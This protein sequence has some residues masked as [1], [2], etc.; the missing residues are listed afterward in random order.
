MERSREMTQFLS[1]FADPGAEYS[2]AP[3][4][5]WNDDLSEEEISRQMADFRAHGVYGFVIHPRAGLPR[6]IQWMSRRM[7]DFIRFAVEEAARTGMWVVLYDEGMYPSGSSAGQVVDADPNY[8]PHGLFCLDATEY[9]NRKPKSD[10]SLV[11]MVDR[12]NGDKVAIVD[13]IISEGFSVIRGLHFVDDDPPRRA[14]KK[15]VAEDLPPAADILNPDAMACF[16]RLVYQRYY[17]ELAEH[18]GK[19]I[20]AIFT[21]EPSFMGKRSEPGAVPGN[22]DLVLYVSNYLG[23]DFAPHLPSLWFD[24]EPE[25]KRHRL[26]YHRALKARLEE[27]YYQPLSEWCNS[28]GIALTGH[29]ADPDDIGQLKYFQIPGQDIVLRSVEPG[30]DSALV[31]PQSTQAKCA[32][33]AM[34]HQGRNRNSNEYCGAYGHGFTFDEMKWLANWLL[35]RGCNLLYPHAF[36]Y[37]VRGPRI[38]ERPPDVGP[39]SS[40]WNQFLP[41]AKATSRLCWLNTG[42]W[43]VCSMA[44]LGLAD[45]LPWKAAKVCFE[46]QYDFNYLETCY[47]QKDIQIT[48]KGISIG[49]MCYSGLIVESDVSVPDSE[50]MAKIERS[51]R[52]IRWND[53]DGESR[54]LKRI[55]TLAEPEVRVTPECRHLRVR[56]VIKDGVDCYLL[57]NEGLEDISVDIEFPAKGRPIV[58]D[59][60]SGEQRD[61]LP[62]SMVQ[63]KANQISAMIIDAG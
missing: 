41:F 10:E 57:F 44:I 24:D 37:S 47:V 11:A 1:G 34:I 23:Y 38:D 29:P 21:D 50:T 51:G 31:G 12:I 55:Q 8:R 13:R 62:G 45:Y 17:D 27:T 46:H 32:S 60:E 58:I 33:S 2:Q 25:A 63:L 30:K 61:H 36:Y 5:F 39:N 59:L 42:S 35:V 53:D 28:H 3:F 6:T 52:I 49:P 54:L 22:T 9:A 16:V 40:W 20:V 26:N 15:E 19:T 48:D 56:H 7:H 4:W 18:F 43:H 14:E